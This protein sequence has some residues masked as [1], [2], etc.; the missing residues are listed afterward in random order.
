MFYVST[1]YVFDG[2][3][4]APYL[5][6]DDTNPQ[7]VYGALEAGGGARARSRARPIVRT[8]WVCGYHGGN[9]VKTI[10]RLAGEHDTLCVRRR[11][12]GPSRPSPTTSPAMIKR[13]VVERRPGTFHVT[14]QGA[15]S[16]Y[17]FAREVLD[18]RGRTTPTG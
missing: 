17:E 13:L 9:M 10:L 1:D 4:D 3:K 8:S 5:E 6:W 12:A 2:T 15:V 11:P 14:N 18:G 16:W 7:S